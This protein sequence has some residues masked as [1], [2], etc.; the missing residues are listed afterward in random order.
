[1]ACDFHE[2]W[3]NSSNKSGN[4][5]QNTPVWDMVNVLWKYVFYKKAMMVF[6]LESGQCA[7]CFKIN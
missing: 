4:L 7:E 2:N 6:E 1:M 5:S 3:S